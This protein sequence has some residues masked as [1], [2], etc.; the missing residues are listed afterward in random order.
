[1]TR[2]ARQIKQVEKLASLP[3]AIPPS[4]ERAFQE[5]DSLDQCHPESR[6]VNYGTIIAPRTAQDARSNAR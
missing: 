4:L 3:A 6:S 2:L 5:L 1:M